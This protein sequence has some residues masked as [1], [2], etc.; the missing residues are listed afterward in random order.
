MVG[1]A[2]TS[3]LVDVGGS[4]LAPRNYVVNVDHVTSGST[5]RKYTRPIAM[6]ECPALRSGWKTLQSLQLDRHFTSRGEHLQICL[7]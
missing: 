4:T 3:H 7:T 5:S 6:H 1:A 2:Q